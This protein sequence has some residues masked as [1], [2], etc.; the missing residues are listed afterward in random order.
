MRLLHIKAKDSAFLQD[1]K[2]FLTK[3]FLPYTFIPKLLVYSN[4]SGIFATYFNGSLGFA[5]W[6][7]KKVYG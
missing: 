4:N 1:Y 5:A 3:L 7:T 2:A 6:L